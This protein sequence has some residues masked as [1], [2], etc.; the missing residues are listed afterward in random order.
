MQWG[1][2]SCIRCAGLPNR[3]RCELHDYAE[4]VADFTGRVPYCAQL[5]VSQDAF[6]PRFLAL[7]VV[8]QGISFE[9]SLRDCPVEEDLGVDS[10]VV[11]LGRGVP[12][13]C[14][15]LGDAQLGNVG[16]ISVSK[17]EVPFER[18]GIFVM[19]VRAPVALHKVQVL[20]SAALA[21]DLFKWRRTLRGLNWFDG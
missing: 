5:V 3:W 7:F 1:D 19:G 16:K 9:V 17:G 10:G 2:W 12:Q 13:P 8:L 20:R 11:L 18:P 6:A 14:Q 15:F 4:D 21:S